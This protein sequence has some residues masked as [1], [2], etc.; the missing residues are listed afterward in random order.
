M[1][2]ETADPN[3]VGKILRLVRNPEKVKITRST[4]FDL[5]GLYLTKLDVCDAIC[6][7]IDSGKEV[8][9]IVTKYAKDHIGR[10]AYVMKPNLAGKPCYVKVAF[11][12]T[13]TS[14][15]NLLIISAHIDH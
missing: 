6:D 14:D 4:Q 3:T 9:V 1:K 15:E 5:M 7:W 2:K 13:D 10:P 11:Q 8:L 12:E